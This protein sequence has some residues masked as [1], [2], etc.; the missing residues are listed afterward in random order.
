MEVDIMGR[1]VTGLLAFKE[2]VE[3]II[4][5]AEG[6]EQTA[7]EHLS[8]RID[9]LAGKIEGLDAWMTGVTPK[10]EELLGLK[11]DVEEK[12]SGVADMLAW[13]GENR[14]ALEVLISIGDD[15]ATKAAAP[16]EAPPAP[17]ATTGQTKAPTEQTSNEQPPSDPPQQPTD[18]GA[19]G[20]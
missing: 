18:A 13:F 11:A 14:A 1:H 8:G 17:P 7:A 16:A 2:K 15:L 9:G 6:G 5:T 3:A 12:L 10:I 20:A 19:P 4:A